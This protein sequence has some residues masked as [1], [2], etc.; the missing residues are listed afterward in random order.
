MH[1]S[2]VYG[3]SSFRSWLDNLQWFV[4]VF[5]I[6]LAIA[7]RVLLGFDCHVARDAPR[8]RRDAGKDPESWK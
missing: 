6:N 1:G 5:L 2:V 3:P 4:I 7:Q 8:Q